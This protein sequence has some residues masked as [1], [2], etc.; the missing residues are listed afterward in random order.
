MEHD[1]R[2]IGYLF[3]AKKIF[4]QRFVTHAEFAKILPWVA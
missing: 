4:F 2:Y 1:N 3:I